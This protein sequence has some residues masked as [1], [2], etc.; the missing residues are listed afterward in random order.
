MLHQ[1]T[2]CFKN[3]FLIDFRLWNKIETTS[4]LKLAELKKSYEKYQ[5]CPK[6]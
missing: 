3:S 6:K 2:S 4:I 5:K 1:A